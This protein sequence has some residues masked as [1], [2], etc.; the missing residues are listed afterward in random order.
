M[1]SAYDQPPLGALR[2]F[3]GV[4]WHLSFAV[5]TQ[6]PARPATVRQ[7]IKTLEAYVQAPLFRRTDLK[8]CYAD[9]AARQAT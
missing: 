9:V 2:M 6:A 3:E 8:N 5:A 7:Q 1:A 4:P